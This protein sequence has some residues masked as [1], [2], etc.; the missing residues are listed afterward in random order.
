MLVPVTV[1]SPVFK[2]DSETIPLKEL[3][4]KILK[5]FIS[6]PVSGKSPVL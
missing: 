2:N 6:V 4:Q 5:I 1:K 3:L